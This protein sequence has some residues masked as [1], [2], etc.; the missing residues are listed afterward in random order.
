[1]VDNDLREQ[2]V[3]EQNTH[4]FPILPVGL[5]IIDD[6]K[7]MTDNNESNTHNNDKK[8]QTMGKNN[9]ENNVNKQQMST[10]QTNDIN[11]TQ[12]QNKD[13]QSNPK[14]KNEIE[15]SLDDIIEKSGLPDFSYDLS[16]VVFFLF[17]F[18]LRLLKK[19]LPDFVFFCW[20]VFFCDGVFLRPIK[21]Y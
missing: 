21:H 4:Q 11:L 20:L 17:F 1:M 13:N 15:A 19:T 12:K 10:N 9:N 3:D 18:L 7:A 8:Q 14:K 5:E 2:I 6:G 16:F